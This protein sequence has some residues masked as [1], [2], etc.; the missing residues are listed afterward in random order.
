MDFADLFP[1]LGPWARSLAAIWPAPLIKSSSWAFPV[2]QTFHLLGLAALGGCI[3]LPGMRLMG[4]GMT[5]QSPAQIEKA[6][7]PW[8]WG[9]LILLLI[10]GILM[11][12][13]IA[14]RLYSRPAFLVKMIALAA[15]LIL[16]LGVVRSIASRDGVVTTTTKMLAAAAL[17][18]WLAAVGIF[19][20]SMGAAPGAFHVVTAGWLV[21]MAFG[22][23]T[24]RLALGSL[25]LVGVLAIG[26]VTYGVYHPMEEY[27]LV[28][29][30]NRWA[31]R[32]GGVI[33]TGFALWEFSRPRPDPV[34]SQ[35]LVRLIGFF[36]IIAWFTVA[37][38]GRWIGLSGGG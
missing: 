10:T 20:T 37:A 15:A 34:A 2:I 8:L 19:G 3:L 11:S 5:Q 13:V 14:P 28:M 7:R 9:A 17:A 12:L 35:A 33:V 36:S 30:I 6:V 16:S 1:D 18:L 26:I 4:V 24:T 31:V 29:E 23:R 21:V 38:A 22:S 25:T 27:D 32:A